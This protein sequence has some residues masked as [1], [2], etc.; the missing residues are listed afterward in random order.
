MN[1]EFKL[2]LLILILGLFSMSVISAQQTHTIVL[3]CDTTDITKENVNKVCS[4]GQESGIT[5][6]EFT[7]DADIGDII[8]W[9][10]VA[11]NSNLPSSIELS[12]VNHEG[13]EN[14]FGRNTLKDDE[15][16]ITGE[17]VQGEPGDEEKY[18]LKF[19]VYVDGRK[20][21]GTFMIDPR[22]KIRR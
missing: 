14:V 11:K 17:I 20:V 6:E 4:F 8:V 21:N 13:G 19:K 2:R 5:N 18:N 7:L 9:K 12:Q 3:T 10:G 15:G 16:I 22:I 1:K